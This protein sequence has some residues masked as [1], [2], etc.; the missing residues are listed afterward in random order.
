MLLSLY[1]YSANEVF[2]IYKVRFLLYLLYL[3]TLRALY[4]L[5][6]YYILYSSYI[7]YNSHLLHY[8]YYTN[9]ALVLKFL[10]E[11]VHISLL[12][13][14]HFVSICNIKFPRNARTSG[15]RRTFNS[16]INWKEQ[17]LNTLFLPCGFQTRVQKSKQEK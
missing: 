12:H 9:I 16:T 4:L 17:V 15:G 1:K 10:S 6:L 2:T 7:I 8:F 11:S 3:I 5:H 13:H 14:V